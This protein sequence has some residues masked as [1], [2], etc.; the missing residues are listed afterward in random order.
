MN[1]N[2]EIERLINFAIQHKLIKFTDKTYI[3]NQFYYLLQIKPQEEQQDTLNGIQE[4]LEYP[5]QIL[6]NIY[7]YV[8]DNSEL[9]LGLT[10]DM[11]TCR[12]MDV[13]IPHP[14]HIESQFKEIYANNGSSNALEYF[15]NLS[16]ASNYIKMEDI[17][18]NQHWLSNTPYGDLEITINLSKPEKDPK[19]IEKAK[20]Q[21]ATGYPKCLLCLENEGYAGDY[22]KPSRFTHRIIPLSL[23]NET[24][25][26][27]FSPYVYYNQH[28]II[29]SK[30][31]RDMKIDNNTFNAL[32]DFVDMFPDYV[33]GANADIPIVGGSILSHDH[34]QAGKHIFPMDKAQVRE[35]IKFNQYPK[36]KSEVLDWPLS[37]IRLRGNKTDLLNL[38]N[39]ILKNW[40][41]YSDES[42]DVLNYTTE[43]HNAL[44]PILRKIDSNLYQLNLILRN[45]RRTEKYSYG[46]FHP[47]EHLHHIKKENIG[48]I[49]AMGLAILP[50][51]LKNEMSLIEEVL[52]SPD[53]NA[54]S[55]INQGHPLWQHKDWIAELDACYQNIT[56][57]VIQDN[58]KQEI[59]KKF[60][61]VLEC[62]GV[63]KNDSQGNSAF[64]RFIEYNNNN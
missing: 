21:K 64:L 1:I 8:L 59:G 62:S 32:F 51:R 29:F 46:I 6:N 58:I 36:V 26:F 3:C 50:G 31:H 11:V 41:N 44:N 10:K 37:V 14:S 24:W 2:Y 16:I 42:V 5:D 48:L 60:M 12:L 22:T 39:K 43:R 52:L 54:V 63:F 18:K 56:G 20:R 47:H 27:Q 57:L 34:F 7:E 9:N 33:I 53:R 23:N 4:T 28:S 17:N 49:E 13:F 30:Q 38:S 19:E 15:Y 40:I 45:N 25:Y 55:Y 61:Q 35:V